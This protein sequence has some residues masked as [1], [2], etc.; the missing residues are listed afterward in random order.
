MHHT[1]TSCAAH[2]AQPVLCRSLCLASPGCNFWTWHDRTNTP[3][4]ARKCYV[5][6]D[7]VYAPVAQAGHVSGVCNQTL[8]PP[9]AVGGV[10][11]QS[12]G[13]RL[14]DFVGATVATKVRLRCTAS[15]AGDCVAYIRSLSLHDAKEGRMLA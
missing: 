15:L 8:A 1:L 12:V 7:T 14:L 10:H 9:S 5:R 11:G 6:T 3:E 13:S 4:W 2:S